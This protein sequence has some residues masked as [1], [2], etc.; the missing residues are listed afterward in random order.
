M[1]RAIVGVCIVV[2][3]TVLSWA[4]PTPP[5]PSSMA[6]KANQRANFNGIE[7]A[8]ATLSDALD[9]LSKMYAVTFDYNDQAFEMDQLKDVRR[10]PIA[11]PTPI[12][13]MKNV[14]LSRLLGTI[15]R[16]VPAPSGATYTVRDDHIEITT[17]TFQRVEIWGTYQGPFL[18]L[19]NTR[20]DKC[21]LE[22]AV[23]QLGDQAQFTVLVDRRAADKAKTPVS[24]RFLNTPLDTALRLLTDMADLQTVHLDNVLYVTTKEN[25][26]DLETRLEKERGPEDDQ[27]PE[28][29]MLPGKWRKGS[30]QPPI[31]NRNAAVAQ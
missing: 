30:G 24:A 10:T 18:P 9:Q 29:I 1:Y 12:P 8:R 14:R 27:A 7:D 22:D 28:G 15:L 5:Q 20:L 6:D 17:T 4:A 23:R 3:L 13:A 2:G 31:V 11:D 19:V 16:R 21:P 26:A 25:A